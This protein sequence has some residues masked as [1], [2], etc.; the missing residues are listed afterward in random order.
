VVKPNRAIEFGDTKYFV[1]GGQGGSGLWI[2]E[3][4]QRALRLILV[5][6]SIRQC[7]V[8]PSLE[9]LLVLS[10]KVSP[11]LHWYRAVLIG[12]T[13]SLVSFKLED[14]ASSKISSRQVDT[15]GSVVFFRIGTHKQ[16]LVLVVAVASGQVSHANLV[17]VVP[18]IFSRA[19]CILCESTKSEVRRQTR[20]NVPP[21]SGYE[22]NGA[23]CSGR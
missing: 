16:S 6:V 1:V 11:A 10:G 2:R 17:L 21:S 7:T 19:P 15:K 3:A 5:G 4:N 9:L 14:I 12:T 8:V 20:A 22:N 13:Q 18:D 23:H